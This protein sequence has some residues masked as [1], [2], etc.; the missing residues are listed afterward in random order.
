M[1]KLIKEQIGDDLFKNKLEILSKCES[2]RDASKTPK[3]KQTTSSEIVL[4]H[5]FITLYLYSIGS[6]KKIF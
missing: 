6:I 1:K 4:D 3:L 2:F 5:D